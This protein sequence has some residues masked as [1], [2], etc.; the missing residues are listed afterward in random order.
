MYNYNQCRRPWFIEVERPLRT[1]YKLPYIRSNNRA[2]VRLRDW[3]QLLNCIWKGS[4]IYVTTKTVI[5]D[6]SFVND[7]LWSYLNFSESY[8]KN[9]LLLK[10][11]YLI[12][13]ISYFWKVMMLGTNM[14]KCLVE[15][16]VNMLFSLIDYFWMDFT[17]VITVFVNK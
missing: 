2:R 1:I 13:L 9:F 6:V 10:F 4:K 17:S 11:I 16:W 3:N 12:L 8:L 7:L 14:R 5:A 15:I